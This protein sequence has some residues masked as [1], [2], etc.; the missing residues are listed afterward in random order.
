MRRSLDRPL[1]RPLDRALDR[2]L[3]RR[4]IWLLLGLLAGCTAPAFEPGNL[5]PRGRD[6]P[7]GPGLFSGPSGAFTVLR[8][9]IERERAA[10]PPPLTAP[11]PATGEATR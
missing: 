2:A 7:D 1:D 10:T 6:M 11:P 3:D 8:R 9:P 5:G 4:S